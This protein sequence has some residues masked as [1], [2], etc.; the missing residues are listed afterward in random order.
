MN[1]YK[2]RI[3]E[4]EAKVVRLEALIEKLLDH[5]DDLTHRK[6]SRNSSVPP[7]KDENRPL[8][9]KSLRASKGK[10]VGGQPGHEGSTLEM[11]GSPDAIIEHQP[12]FCNHCG[13]DLSEKPATFIQR[14][15]VV[16][17]PPI[18][19]EF[20]EHR[21]FQ[22][23]CA[24]GHHTKATFPSG[25]NSPISYGTEIQATIAYM[26]TRQYLPFERMSEFFFDVCNLKISQGTL[27]T[28]LKG[29]AEKARP[30]YGLIAQKVENGKLVG[31]DETG[32][33]VNGKK[34][35]FW[36]FQS[37]AATYITFSNN[38]GTATIEENFPKGFMN[39]IL[40]HDCWRSYFQVKCKTHQICIPH[41][42][43]ELVFFEERYG[44]KWAI[45]FKELLCQAMELKRDLSP[46]QYL[47]PIPKRDEIMERLS[48]LLLNSVPENRKDLCA[49]HKRMQKYKEYV[50]TFLF[51]DQV[52]PDNNASERA[53][54]NVKVKQKVSG[55]FKTQ[56]GAKCYAIIRSVT[57]TCIK[58]GQNVLN[59][60]KTI[61]KLQPE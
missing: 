1:S 21:I 43:R 56:N 23:T 24:C 55:Q 58:N 7:S 17:I 3:V 45:D 53:I 41:L 34:G 33:K 13:D 50:F 46:P 16:D 61:A 52:P 44:S 48:V 49:F 15:Q 36:T 14:R 19:T 35:W 54:R 22:K 12:K 5:I 32:A 30:A 59:A 11:T 6:D 37:Q 20:T 28:L 27:C 9:T 38:R 8:K 42:L 4:L 18:I 25:V 51:Y 31:G 57:D 60:F 29:F 26:H 10:K 40:V 47:Q 39:A 2:E